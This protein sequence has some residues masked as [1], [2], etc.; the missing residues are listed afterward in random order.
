MRF[1]VFCFDFRSQVTSLVTSLFTHLARS[2]TVQ[3]STF[4]IAPCNMGFF[5]IA[6]FVNDKI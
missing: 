5:C 3:R 4:H 1:E 2:N 6:S